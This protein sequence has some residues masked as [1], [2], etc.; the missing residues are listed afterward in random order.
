MQMPCKA[1]EVLLAFH[2]KQFGGFVPKREIKAGF[3]LHAPSRVAFEVTCAPQGTDRN[4]TQ[5]L[6]KSF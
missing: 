1:M 6:L 5:T 2:Q 4:R 3:F